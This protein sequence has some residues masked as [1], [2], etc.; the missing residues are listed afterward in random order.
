MSHIDD[1]AV[2]V[3]YANG[4]V[5]DGRAGPGVVRSTRRA[6]WYSIAVISTTMLSLPLVLFGEL[7][8]KIEIAHLVFYGVSV[9]VGALGLGWA[10]TTN[11]TVRAQ[12]PFAIIFFAACSGLYAG[13]R[14]I[15]LL[16][17]SVNI[18]DIGESEICKES[19]IY[20]IPGTLIYGFIAFMCAAIAYSTYNV[21]NAIANAK[22]IHYMRVNSERSVD[23]DDFA[24][25]EPV[26]QSTATESSAARGNRLSLRSALQQ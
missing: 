9:L 16:Y 25:S 17:C 8:A 19:L 15:V 24:D 18:E 2:H 23:M 1:G 7:V 21:R 3:R 20:E 11:A 12:M 10:T 26:A 5:V 22:R 14:I 6:V 4:R 13:F